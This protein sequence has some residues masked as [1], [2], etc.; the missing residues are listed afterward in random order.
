MA[1]L[2]KTVEHLK[3]VILVGARDFGRCPVASRLNRG[4]WPVLGIPALQRLIDALSAQGVCRFVI[5][6]ESQSDRVR[7]SIEWESDKLEVLFQQE[8]LPRGPAGC[9]RDAAAVD[10]E[11]LLV[12]PAA[13]INPPNVVELLSQHHQCQGQMTVFRN[14]LHCQQEDSQV[15]LCNR[16]ILD[17]IPE[18]GYFDIKEGL[19]PAM[20]HNDQSIALGRLSVESGHYRNWR[21]YI[22]HLKRLCRRQVNTSQVPD[23]FVE[24][25]NQ[26]GVWVGHDVSIS[27]NVRFYGPVVIG[28]RTVIAPG[29]II[30]GPSVI[31]DD[32][33]IGFECIIEESVIWKRAVFCDQ[34]RVRYGMVDAGKT[35]STQT[36]CSGQLSALPKLKI[37]KILN[38]S[39]TLACRKSVH[40][41]MNQNCQQA[42]VLT[43]Q[44]ILG[45]KATGFIGPA[46]L[47]LVL[48]AIIFSYWQPA[49]KEMIHIWVESDEYSSGLLVPLVAGYVLWAR[50]SDLARI[51]LNPSWWAVMFVLLA[52]GARFTALYFG[53]RSG[54]MISF[55]LL[56]GAVVFWLLGWRFFKKFIPIFLFLF[57]MLPLPEQVE[58]Q[59]A[60]PLQ[61]WATVSSVFC[62]ETI[63]FSVTRWGNIID[64]NG[65]QVAVAEA[66]NGLRM[67]T[68][69]IVVSGLVAL[70]TNRRWPEKLLILLSSIPIA[71]IC[72]TLR[73]T[74]TAIAFT[75]LDTVRWE[76]IFHDFGGFAMMPVALLLVVLEL[77][78]L[79]LVV[80]QPK[81]INK[82]NQIIYRRKAKSV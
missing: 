50:R 15:Y 82:Q 24:L 3:A 44:N 58:S 53:M 56:I 70:V 75:K 78:L 64:I 20:V 35:L 80:I 76:K 46:M 73:L 4:L 10:D 37:S 51:G 59:L 16:D 67:L 65:T 22:T 30:F 34:S 21:E 71:L 8:S 66:C 79:S 17:W 26:P 6:C 13:I 48:A 25:E 23:G 49:L 77:R 52:F 41:R 61:E 54:E 55:V 2:N 45:R 27:E 47:F 40:K 32:V 7:Q 5:S 63:G 69:F 14:P 57:L 62:L 31:G 39:C 60:V 9:I 68:A 42:D 36:V 29:S 11:L 33:T 43:L 72:N 18:T 28:N 19:I 12:L 74:V 1:E 38:K 81:R